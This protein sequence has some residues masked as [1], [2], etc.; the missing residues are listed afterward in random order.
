MCGIDAGAGIGCQFEA[1]GPTVAGQC[2]LCAGVDSR[3]LYAPSRRLPPQ[4]GARHG[5]DRYRQSL[6]VL[7]AAPGQG[8]SLWRYRRRGGASMVRGGQ[9]RPD[10]GVAVLDAHC[11]DQTP[12][13]QYSG[14]R[15]PRAP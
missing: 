5:G 9:D 2:A 7:R 15:Q 10:G 1:E 12:P 8:D 3:D 4:G 13:G 6:L 14:F 11:R